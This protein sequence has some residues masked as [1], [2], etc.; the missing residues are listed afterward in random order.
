MPDFGEVWV[1]LNQFC[2][3]GKC[4]AK[5]VGTVQPLAQQQHYVGVIQALSREILQSVGNSEA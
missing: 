2:I 1:G 3:V 5:G 4:L